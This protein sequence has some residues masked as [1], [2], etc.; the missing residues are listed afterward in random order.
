MVEFHSAEKLLL[1]ISCL[2]A[3]ALHHDPH[4]V[5]RAEGFEFVHDSVEAAHAHHVG[6]SHSEVAHG[7]V[8]AAVVDHDLGR[9]VVQD[10]GLV[11]IVGREE[12]A[13]EGHSHIP[14]YVLGN[15]FHKV[16]Q[17]ESFLFGERVE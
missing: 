14:P 8:L 5:R 15:K 7:R 9:A 10:R 6:R 1:D 13:A 2:E 4:Q 17:A 16:R 12:K 3:E 11:E